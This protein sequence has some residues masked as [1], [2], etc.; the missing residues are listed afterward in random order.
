[1]FTSFIFQ[2]WMRVKY[3][4]KSARPQ[5]LYRLCWIGSFFPQMNTA[6]NK[7]SFF[8]TSSLRSPSA[9]KKSIQTSVKPTSLFL[10]GQKG[11]YTLASTLAVVQV[12]PMFILWEVFCFGNGQL[13]DNLLGP[14][15][16]WVEGF[17][18]IHIQHH[19][20]LNFGNSPNFARSLPNFTYM[21][22]HGTRKCFARFLL[23]VINKKVFQVG[24]HHGTKDLY[25]STQPSTRMLN[26][27]NVQV[28]L[29]A[30]TM[31]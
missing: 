14:W 20:P 18:C 28:L 8:P 24:T 19:Q 27:R 16:V 4:G 9:M 22:D 30:K 25:F 13:F 10:K 26:L 29:H 3:S 21:E 2:R 5:V 15:M 23:K 17:N 6:N 7:R 11:Q 1:M 12:Y 31:I